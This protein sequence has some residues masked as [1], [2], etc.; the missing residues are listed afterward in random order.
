MGGETLQL[1]VNN[2]VVRTWK[3]NTDFEYYHYNPKNSITVRNVEIHLPDARYQPERGI[4]DNLTIDYIE[5]NGQRYETEA[6][7]NYSQ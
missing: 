1:R 7:G 3:V 5:V 2:S 4:Q 6:S